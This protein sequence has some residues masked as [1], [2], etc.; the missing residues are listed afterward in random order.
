MLLIIVIDC[1]Y[2]DMINNYLTQNRGKRISFEKFSN[3]LCNGMLHIRTKIY[4]SNP[5]KS[6]EATP[7]EEEAY[8]KKQNFFYAINRIK[9]HEFVPVG[10]V[11]P[12]SVHCPKCKKDFS[13]NKQKGVDVSIALDLVKMAQKRFADVFIL[14]SGD[15]DLSSAIEMAQ[16]QLC[17]VIVYYCY[18]RDFNIFG[19]KK[20]NNTASDR[21]QMDLDFLEDCAMDTT[22]ATTLSVK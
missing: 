5:Y 21:F 8:R 2:F 6:L 10:R 7:E 22:K 1:G 13:V 19:S 17:N 14:V 3:K 20:L 9:N 4:H 15:E 18:D 12:E 16:E 11:R